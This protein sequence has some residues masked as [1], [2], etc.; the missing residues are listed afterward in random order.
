MRF[1]SI[2]E[3]EIKVQKLLD[4]A[5]AEKLDRDQT[6]DA[7]KGVVKNMWLPLD[8]VALGMANAKELAIEL[9]RL[10]RGQIDECRKHARQMENF[11]KEL[12]AWSENMLIK[13]AEQS[14]EGETEKQHATSAFLRAMVHAFEQSN[15]FDLLA[16]ADFPPGTV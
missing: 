2:K 12:S 10:N 13:I 8:D 6:L 1:R 16:A 15:F 5:L 7:V 14:L 11:G 4:Q 9:N 3:S